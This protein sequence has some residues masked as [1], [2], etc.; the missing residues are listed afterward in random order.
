MI[1]A[2]VAADKPPE[3]YSPEPG[4]SASDPLLLKF[5]WKLAAFAPFVSQQDIAAL[6]TAGFT[7]S[8]VVE[9]VATIAAARFLRALRT[10]LGV[11]IEPSSAKSFLLK[12]SSETPPE[13]VPSERPYI[14]IP[15][16][17][18]GELK[19]A[20]SLLREQFGFV[21]NLFRIQSVCPAIA[22]AEVEMLAAV[23][24]PEEHLTRLD[25]EQIIL[26]V[27]SQN[28]DP[29]LVAVHSRI[30]GLLG[31]TAEECDLVI[32]NLEGAPLVQAN[33]T[34]MEELGK[35][36]LYPTSAGQSVNR[37]RIR[38][39]GLTEPQII[40]GIVLA[41]FTSFLSTVQFGLGPAPDFPLRRSFNPNHL[42]PFRR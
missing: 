38:E 40:E 9:T 19:S 11:A 2:I 1:N 16:M 37:D 14:P 42:Y 27:A 15:S 20:F 32:D 8:C 30:L 35:I 21:P 13:Y 41:A 22:N 12:L 3:A 7:E 24:F 4:S 17:E 18:P 36:S 39:C 29:Y 34:L 31:M 33:R 26:R 5:A 10:G 6:T 28:F 23:L 25:K